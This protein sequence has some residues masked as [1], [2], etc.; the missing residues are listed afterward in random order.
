VAVAVAVLLFICQMFLLVVIK[1]IPLSLAPAVFQGRV[2]HLP[3]VALAKTLQRLD[4]LPAAAVLAVVMVTMELMVGAVVA[5]AV[6]MVFL[7]WAVMS[8]QAP[9]LVAMW[10]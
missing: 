4:Q 7:H 8:V 2:G 9:H 3:L 5:S 1:P 6:Q 10:G